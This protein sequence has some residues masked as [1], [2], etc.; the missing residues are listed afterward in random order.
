MPSSSLW[1]C[2]WGL[3][4]RKLVI[5]SRNPGK[6]AEMRRFLEGLGIVV[7]GLDAFPN[8]PEVQEDGS[9]FTENSL[10]KARAVAAYTGLPAIADDSGLEVDALAG[11]PG[12][13]SARFAG[14][15]ATDEQNNRKLLEDMAGIPPNERSARYRTVISLVVPEGYFDHSP[16]IEETVEG[17]VDGVIASKPRGA[18]GFGYD[19]VFHVPEV[20]KTFAELSTEEREVFSHRFRA[21]RQ[22]RPLLEEIFRLCSGPC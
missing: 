12:V 10:K 21:L 13:Y 3:A 14:P 11:Q 19:P 15:G 7:L 1:G 17:V 8:I 18:S 9:T 6:V 2:S 5:A 22:L 20:G 16:Y 4:E